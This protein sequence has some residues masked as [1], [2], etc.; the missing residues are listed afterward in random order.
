MN[1]EGHGGDVQWVGI[2]ALLGKNLD[3][4]ID[5]ITTEAE[6]MDLKSDYTGLVE[7][8]VIESKTVPTRG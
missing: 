6:M 2:S 5:A 7:G 1:L 3:K 4:L 8:V